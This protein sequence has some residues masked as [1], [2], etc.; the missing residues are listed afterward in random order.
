MKSAKTMFE[1]LGFKLDCIQKEFLLYTQRTD[2]NS[3]YVEFEMGLKS[4]SVKK[5]IKGC[6]GWFREDCLVSP[7]LHNAIHQQM[8]ELGWIE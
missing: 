8:I 3:I 2:Y 6:G 1:E 5:Y 7:D 4:Y